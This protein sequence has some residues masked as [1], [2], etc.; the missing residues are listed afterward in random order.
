MSRVNRTSFLA[1]LTVTE[2][3]GTGR[4]RVS[5][6]YLDNGYIRRKDDN[7][8]M[9]KIEKWSWR[10]KREPRWKTLPAANGRSYWTQVD[11]F[12]LKIGHGLL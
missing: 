3:E 9:E 10:G 6:A 2:L 11:W 7:G 4:E 1:F 5:M 8:V 12:G